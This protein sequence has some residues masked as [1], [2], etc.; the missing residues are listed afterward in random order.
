MRAD[1]LSWVIPA[2][3]EARSLPRLFNEIS[4]ISLKNLE[5]I[6]VDD[7]SKDFSYNV[8]ITI[9]KS[10]PNLKIIRFKLPRGKWAALEAGFKLASGE[11]IITSD[12]DLQDDPKEVLKLLNKFQQGYDLVSGWRKN[13]KDP[14]YKVWI[15]NIG[16][17]FVSL[18]SG[19]RFKDLNSPFK[20]YRREVFESLPSHGSLLRFS[21]L[22]AKK[23]GYK[24]DEVPVYH[25]SRLYGKSK[26]GFVKY[27]RIFYDLVLVFLLFSG[28]G[29]LAKALS[30]KKEKVRMPR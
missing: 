11:I 5:V 15:S 6:V 30:A 1:V 22:F 7:G 27:I 17:R 28:S 12:S 23:M 18:V 3:D 21:A 8:L 4:E 29:R 19:Y 26:F 9:A 2:R 25:R 16:N 14:L 10:F 20:V 24:V 13:R